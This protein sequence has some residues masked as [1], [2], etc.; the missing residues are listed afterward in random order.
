MDKHPRVCSLLKG[1]FNKRA[2]VPR[3]IFIWEVVKV[4]TYFS[5]LGMPEHINDK[6]LTLKTTLLLALTSSPRAHEICSLGFLVKLATYYTFHFSKIT[7]LQSN[8]NLDL[9]L[10][11]ISF[12]IRIFVYVII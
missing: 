3:Y 7:K 11:E 12:L 4:P 6:M 5:T 2:L 8:V 1:I 10:S 9:Q